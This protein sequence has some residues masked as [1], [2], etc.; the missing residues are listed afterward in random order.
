M[1][2]SSTA[3]RPEKRPFAHLR[4]EERIYFRAAAENRL[5]F[6]RCVACSAMQFPPRSVCSSCLGHELTI[7]DAQGQGSI[8]SFTVVHRPGHPAFRDCVPYVVVLVDLDEGVRVIADLEIESGTT[9][10]VGDRV[11]AF[12]EPHDEEYGVPRFRLILEG[13]STQ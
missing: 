8:Y 3:R 10:R 2:T 5:V 12:F 1:T 4:G 9:P 6:Q 11:E 7:E 13:R